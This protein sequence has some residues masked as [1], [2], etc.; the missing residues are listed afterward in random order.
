[1]KILIKNR[2]S[3]Y[4][5]IFIYIFFI[6]IVLFFT[7]SSF[8]FSF[9][10]FHLYPKHDL[11]LSII[12]FSTK[13]LHHHYPTHIIIIKLWL[14]FLH[15]TTVSNSKHINTSSKFIITL[16]IAMPWHLG[17]A[18]VYIYHVALWLWL[19]GWT[20]CVA[21]RVCFSYF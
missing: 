17:A 11:G 10:L 8:S 7:L 15:I 12:L 4:L 21:L 1:M 5:F 9:F 19:L 3:F 20:I 2:R 18:L 14:N 6:I 16:L 13:I